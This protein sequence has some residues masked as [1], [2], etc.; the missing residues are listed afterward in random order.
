MVFDEEACRSLFDWLYELYG[1]SVNT[2]I[3]DPF[4]FDNSE[5]RYAGH[6]SKIL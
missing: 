4:E 1:K 2:I 3:G 6:G 5:K